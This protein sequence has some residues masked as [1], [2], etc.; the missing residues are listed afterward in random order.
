MTTVCKE[1]MCTGCMACVEA[2]SKAAIKI[3]DNLKNYNAVIE[4]DKCIGCEKCKHIC[5]N[6]DIL[7]LKKPLRWQQGWSESNE[8]RKKAASGGMASSI[9]EA[10]IEKKDGYVCGCTFFDG[11]FQF[12]I[13]NQISEIQCF[14][15]SKYVKSNPKKI[16]NKIRKLLHNKENVLFI[17]LPCQVAGLKKYI[18]NDLKNLYTIDLICHGT[19]S[20]KLLECYLKEHGLD[21]KTL[22]DVRFREKNSFRL[23]DEYNAITN[24]DM[25][26]RYLFAFLKSLIYTD[27]CFQCNFAGENR[28]A[29]I[30]L[31]DSW[32][33]NLSEEEKKRGISLIMSQTEKGKELVRLANVHLENVDRITAMEHNGQ[34][35]RPVSYNLKRDSFFKLLTQG[36]KIDRIIFKLY[37]NIFIKQYI[38][39]ILRK[40]KIIRE[41]IPIV[42]Y[43]LYYKEKNKNEN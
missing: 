22:K 5:Q 40:A 34:L 14:A 12:K 23:Y 25:P 15:G 2:C 24:R 37:P 39:F 29:D 43:G 41:G 10:F 4:K 1:N 21:L 19:P 26:D 11:S 13:V 27:N 8:I 9:M 36:G 7:E 38:K 31:G 35:N 16:Y 18:G 42:R 17:G 3:V 28:I 32:G 30:T 20:P 33:S 6:N